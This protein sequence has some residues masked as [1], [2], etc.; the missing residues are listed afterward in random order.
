MYD[1]QKG[2]PIIH[3]MNKSEKIK[4]G[5]LLPRKLN[6]VKFTGKKN[7]VNLKYFHFD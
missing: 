2:S 4:S 5:P 7:Q 1:D 6:I 3:M